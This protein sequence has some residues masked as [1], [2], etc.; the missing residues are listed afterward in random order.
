MKNQHF[1]IGFSIADE[2]SEQVFLSVTKGFEHGP[3]I[4]RDGISSPRMADPHSVPGVRNTLRIPVD[5][6][7]D[8]LSPTTNP[9]VQRAG[10]WTLYHHLKRFLE[11]YGNEWEVTAIQSNGDLTMNQW[12]VAHIDRRPEAPPILCGLLTDGDDKEPVG[13][14]TYRALVK[15][16]DLA[17]RI[18]GTRNEFMDIRFE[19]LA[20]EAWLPKA[21]D[22]AVAE[23]LDGQFSRLPEYDS[24]THE[25]GS[26]MEFCLAGKPI[27]EKG[28]Q[29]PFTNAIDRFQDLRHVFNLPTVAADGNFHRNKVNSINLGEFQL[30]KNLN[31]RRAATSSPIIVNL[32]LDGFVTSN[33]IDV[34]EALHEKHFTET[35]KSPSRRG[36]FRSYGDDQIEIYFPHNVYPFGVLGI[37]KS[38][39]GTYNQLVGLSSGGLSGRVGN[40][41]EGITQIMFD[42]LGCTDA[43]VLDEGFDVFSIINSDGYSNEELLAKIK[44]FS[45]KQLY[46]DSEDAR[47]VSLSYRFGSN[48][49]SWPLNRGLVAEL[50]EGAELVADVHHDDIVSVSPL[51]SQM[52]S[53]LIFANRTSGSGS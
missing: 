5:W 33:W 32:N 9:F 6:Q 50:E 12:H 17:S 15:W 36:E 2:E 38:D 1:D 47:E 21:A 46:K 13:K 42:F 35:L 7:D 41:L 4:Q 53:V 26:V 30:F 49:K 10:T 14:R 44:A 29:V 3:G 52:R 23:E 31:E 18:R 8:D 28:M 39:S 19:P 16:N 11:R 45:I 25:L 20:G 40:T 22:T 43:M 24:N 37:R 34:R 27:V 48:L 51:R